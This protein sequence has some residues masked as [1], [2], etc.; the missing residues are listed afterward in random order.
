MARVSLMSRHPLDPPAR[1]LR[2]LVG[3]VAAGVAVGLA[4]GLMEGP[5]CLDAL[6][7]ALRARARHLD[8][9]GSV[10]TP[11]GLRTR[12]ADAPRPTASNFSTG[13]FS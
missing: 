7:P 11:S 12:V 5:G 6:L 3:M 1:L 8:N 9:F 10:P 13:E 4:V 2:S